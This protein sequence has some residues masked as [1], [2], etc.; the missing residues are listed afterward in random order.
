MAPRTL[1]LM[2]KL[3]MLRE[4]FITPMSLRFLWPNC[5]LQDHQN[6]TK[7]NCQ[8]SNDYELFIK[9]TYKRNQVEI[10]LTSGINFRR[11]NHIITKMF[12]R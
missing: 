7:V 6:V 5:T 1:P 2:M 4:R 12:C 10:R 8:Q 9:Q 11:N 3:G